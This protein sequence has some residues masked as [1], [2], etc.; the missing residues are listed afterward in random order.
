MVVQATAASKM[1]RALWNSLQCMPHHSFGPEHFP[2]DYLVSKRLDKEAQL[3]VRDVDMC[4]NGCRAFTGNYEKDT[5][6]SCGEAR[7]DAQVSDEC[8]W[9]EYTSAR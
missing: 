1:S 2:S 4:V 6:C 7:Y 3:Q 8:G 9:L 5:S